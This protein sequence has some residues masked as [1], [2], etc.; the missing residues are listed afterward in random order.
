[1]I[2]GFFVAFLPQKT[3]DQL[4]RFCY[5]SGI[6]RKQE[7]AMPY[8]LITSTGKIMQFYVKDV[9]EM[10]RVGLGGVVFSQQMLDQKTV[11]Q[12]TQII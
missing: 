8:T 5:N 3:V 7:L 2:K 9:A 11:D 1:M 12:K 4:A 6:L 10:Y